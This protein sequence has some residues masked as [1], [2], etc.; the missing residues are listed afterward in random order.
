MHIGSGYNQFDLLQKI[1]YK[2][3]EQA[4][5]S[6]NL[7]YSQS[8]NIPRY[9]NLN[10]YADS[11]L[12]TLRWAE[13][14]YGPQVRMFGAFNASY[15]RDRGAFTNASFTLAFQRQEESRH[16]RRFGNPNRT[17]RWEAVDAVTLNAD[18]SKDLSERTRF[19]YGLEAVYND[20]NSTAET[21]NID[22]DAIVAASTRYPDGGSDVQ[23]GGLYANIRHTFG[24]TERVTASL[25]ARMNATRME[26]SF[27]DTS[28]IQLPFNSI[29][30]NA[31]APTASAGIVFR[32]DEL[33]M[34]R[35]TAA[36]GFR[37]PNVDDNGKVFEKNDLVTVPNNQLK[38]EYTYNGEIAAARSLFEKVVTVEATGFYTYLVDA[39]VRQDW[40]LNGQDSVLYDGV[41]GRVVTNLNTNEAHIYGLGV[42]LD[43]KASENLTFFGTYNYTYGRDLTANEPLAH[44][45][46]EF[47]RLSGTWQ[48]DRIRGDFFINYNNWKHLRDYSPTG[49]DNLEEATIAGTPSWYTLNARFGYQLSKWL[50]LQLAIENILD[51]HYKPFASGMSGPGRNFVFTF[52]AGF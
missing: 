24:K 14:Y 37:A 11:T 29:S 39:I 18:L 13:W 12:S 35:A 48:N 36:T 51:K 45:P 6:L 23:Q 34:L 22:E 46:P 30:V 3:S 41:P 17:S 2:P 27:N 47:G 28:F 7:Q 31:A 10:D 32:P 9:D 50:Q 49:T 5:Y 8:S 19:N 43:V 42:R 38:P 16:T 40:Q 44:I 52:R 33:T 21:R 15:Q 4:Q 20:V 1:I 25:G 26:L